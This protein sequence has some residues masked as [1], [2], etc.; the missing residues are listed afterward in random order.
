MQALLY[1]GLNSNYSEGIKAI[2]DSKFPLTFDKCD[3]S[4]IL[5]QPFMAPT[6]TP[7]T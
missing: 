1:Q 7:C 3:R 4:I 6:T 2:H 5:G